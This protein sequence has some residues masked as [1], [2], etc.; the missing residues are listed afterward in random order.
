MKELTLAYLETKLVVLNIDLRFL[1][2]IESLDNAL[3]LRLQL[4]L[5]LL[6]FL[7]GELDGLIFIFL[8]AK[9]HQFVD[10]LLGPRF[11]TFIIGYEFE[12][13]IIDLQNSP[14]GLFL[15]D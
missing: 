8:F 6:L 13:C 3:Y 15:T 5:K 4:I 14:L 9:L 10:H 1:V 2:F 7:T 12:A 11:Y